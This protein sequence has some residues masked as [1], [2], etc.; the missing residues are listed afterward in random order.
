MWAPN[1][2]DQF[3]VLKGGVS[4]ATTP[5]VNAGYSP[6]VEPTTG[7]PTK[8]DSVGLTTPGISDSWLRKVIVN[9][10]GTPESGLTTAQTAA[11]TEFATR[12]VVPT[13][14]AK[15][16]VCEALKKLTTP[17]T[18]NRLGISSAEVQTVMAHVTT[19][20]PTPDPL[21]IAADEF[22]KESM[23]ENGYTPTELKYR[24][25]VGLISPKDSNI[26]TIL[27]EMT[28]AGTLK[29]G[30]SESDIATAVTTYVQTNFKYISDGVAVEGKPADHWN[31]INETMAAR[32][33]DCEDLSVLTASL[34]MGALSKSGVSDADIHSKVTLA[35]GYLVDKTGAAKGHATV[36]F[37]LDN[38]KS[39]SLDATTDKPPVAFDSLNMLLVLE[40]NDTTFKQYKAIDEFFETAS[41]AKY[42]DV[43][44]GVESIN[45]KLTTLKALLENPVEVPLA[46]A[47]GTSFT[48][49]DSVT[50]VEKNIT[51]HP[52]WDGTS[53]DFGF[54]TLTKTRIAD[55]G[56]SWHSDMYVTTLNEQ[57]FY[58]F[59]TQSR[60]LINRAV[61]MFN[62]INMVL[63]YDEHQ[64]A[65]IA[66][67]GFEDYQKS[68]LL[69]TMGSTGKFKNRFV[70]AMNN[71]LGKISSSIE[72]VVNE[73]FIFISGTNGAQQARISAE[74]EEYG[75]ENLA[76]GILSGL[77]DEI[78]GKF[79]FVRATASLDLNATMAKVNL[80]NA[81][82]YVRYT[83]KFGEGISLWDN[84]ALNPT[85]KS[86]LTNTDSFLNFGSNAVNNMDGFS[87]INNK[88][89]IQNTLQRGL[90]QLE[91]MESQFDS[92]SGD[93]GASLGVGQDDTNSKSASVAANNLNLLGRAGDQGQYAEMGMNYILRLR[94][95]MV[96]YQNFIR[97]T[98]MITEAENSAKRQV[99]EQI[100]ATSGLEE[101]AKNTSSTTQTKSVVVN[102]MSTEIQRQS[103]GLSQIDFATRPFVDAANGYI[104]GRYK[105]A[106]WYKDLT[107]KIQT[108]LEIALQV[109]SAV[110]APIVAT[111][112][113][114]ASLI[115][116]AP[117]PLFVP[118]DPVGWVLFGEINGDYW[119]NAV[120]D[121]ASAGMNAIAQGI[122]Y[123]LELNKIKERNTNLMVQEGDFYGNSANAA[124]LLK[125]ANLAKL[126]QDSVNPYDES[127]ADYYIGKMDSLLYDS[128]T[129]YDSAKGDSSLDAGGGFTYSLQDGKNGET[130][131]STTDFIATRGDGRAVLKGDAM[132][133][134]Q[135]ATS[136]NYMKVSIY[137]SILK[138]LQDAMEGVT[139]TMF[140]R[141]KT[142][143]V[144]NFDGQVDAIIAKESSII[145]TFRYET[146]TRVATINSQWAKEQKEYNQTVEMG[147][148]TA[149]ALVQTSRAVGEFFYSI[150][151][152][153]LGEAALFSTYVAV[154]EAL[155][156]GF[157]AEEAAMLANSTWGKFGFTNID[158][159]STNPYKDSAVNSN[160]VSRLENADPDKFDQ[161]KTSNAQIFENLN[162][163]PNLFP[164]PVASG[165]VDRIANQYGK[166]AKLDEEEAQILNSIKDPDT[167]LTDSSSLAGIGG[168]FQQVD[169]E[170]V[171]DAYK[172][173]T[174]INQI[175]TFMTMIDQAM[176]NA[177]Q[178]ALRSMFGGNAGGGHGALSVMASGIDRYIG[179]IMG[180][181]AGQTGI[182]QDFISEAESRMGA[183]NDRTMGEINTSIQGSLIAANLIFAGVAG[184][185]TYTK[186]VKLAKSG[187]LSDASYLKM[188]RRM[189]SGQMIAGLAANFARIAVG[190]AMMKSVVANHPQIK[191]ELLNYEEDPEEA[192]VN[193]NDS[194][195]EQK[196]NAKLRGTPADSSVNF[197]AKNPVDGGTKT[198][199]SPNFGL[200]GSGS[201]ESQGIKQKVNTGDQGRMERM[202]SRKS[203]SIQVLR[204]IS[205]AMSDA[206][207]DAAEDMGGGPS[208]KNVY[209]GMNSILN[210]Q[211]NLEQQAVGMIFKALNAEVESYNRGVD[212]MV[213]G[214]TGV[215][216]TAV[217]E[218]SKAMVSKAGD[219]RQKANKQSATKTGGSTEEAGAGDNVE[220]SQNSEKPA[221]KPASTDKKASGDTSQKAKTSS[222]EQLNAQARNWEIAAEV[223][224]L[225]GP[226]LA[227]IMVEALSQA[228][229]PDS[230]MGAQAPM[231]S[232]DKADFG[233]Q[234]GDYLSDG[235]NIQQKGGEKSG[236]PAKGG[237]TEGSL[238]FLDTGQ[239]ETAMFANSLLQ[240]GYQVRQQQLSDLGAIYD[241]AGAATA[242]KLKGMA[243]KAIQDHVQEN[244][245]VEE[246]KAADNLV[247][248]H[249]EEA[250]TKIV[251]DA[252]TQTAAPAAQPGG[253]GLRLG[254]RA[255]VGRNMFDVMSGKGGPAGQSNAER[256]LIQKL[257][258]GVADSVSKEHIEVANLNKQ[259]NDKTDTK[260]YDPNWVNKTAGGSVT[261]KAVVDQLR[262]GV[263][264]RAKELD[265]RNG[266]TRS[267]GQM[268]AAEAG[269]VGIIQGRDALEKM[270]GFEKSI[271]GREL[272][273]PEALAAFK[274]AKNDLQVLLDTSTGS[275]SGI[276]RA[277]A[278][279]GADDTFVANALKNMAVGSSAL[280]ELKPV[281]AGVRGAMSMGRGVVSLGGAA[282]RGIGGAFSAIAAP[283][284]MGRAYGAITAP[285]AMR[286]AG[287]SVIG[288]LG[289]VAGAV[290][291]GGGAA[292]GGMGSA[293][294]Y[295]GGAIKNQAGAS[296]AIMK[297]GKYTAY[298]MGLDAGARTELL[299]AEFTKAAGGTLS[300]GLKALA[301]NMAESA[302]RKGF[303][304]KADALLAKVQGASAKIQDSIARGNA[305]TTVSP[306]GSKVT[307]VDLDAQTKGGAAAA[308][309]TEVHM[310]AGPQVLAGLFAQT[311]GD[312]A[313][314]GD[315]P[316]VQMVQGA[317]GK[318]TAQLVDRIDPS[319]HTEVLVTN[320][321]N[322]DQQIRV[323]VPGGASASATADAM[324]K[325]LGEV[326][327]DLAKLRA[328]AAVHTE[329]TAVSGE[330]ATKMGELHALKTAN[331]GQL[332]TAMDR[333][334]ASKEEGGQRN[335]V[336]MDASNR[337]KSQGTTLAGQARAEIEQLKGQQ[338]KLAHDKLQLRLAELKAKNLDATAEKATL[339]ARQLRAAVGEP[340]GDI[341]AA[342]S[343]QEDVARAAGEAAGHRSEAAIHRSDAAGE[344]LMGDRYR[345]DAKMQAADAVGHRF[346]AGGHSS[347]AAR[348]RSDAKMQAADAVGRRN[349]ARA[350]DNA[351][352]GLKTSIATQEKEVKTQ[353]EGLARLNTAFMT[354]I[355]A[356]EKTLENAKRLLEV[357][358]TP[359]D[360]LR[361]EASEKKEEEA[362]FRREEKALR[363]QGD[364]KGAS[365]K[366]VLAVKAEQDKLRLLATADRLVETNKVG[367]KSKAVAKAARALED[368]K[369]TE[370]P[371]V[372]T[373]AEKKLSDAKNQLA[374][375]R[376]KLTDANKKV[377]DLLGAAAK[378]DSEAAKSNAK[379]ADSNAKA[380]DSNA[381]AADSDAKAAG[382]DAKAA[383]SDAKAA[384]SDAKAA[385]SDAKAV[386]AEKAAVRL[387]MDAATLGRSRGVE[388]DA[389]LALAIKAE[390]EAGIHRE[391]AE[392]QHDIVHN[393]KTEVGGQT[394]AVAVKKGLIDTLEATSRGHLAES[395]RLADVHTSESKRLVDTHRVNS[396]RLL[397]EYNDSQAALKKQ[398]IRGLQ[399]RSKVLTAAAKN[400]SGVLVS[401]TSR[402]AALEAEEVDLSKQVVASQMEKE[403][404][405]LAVATGTA[406]KLLTG[407]A[408]QVAQ[409]VAAD[410]E[411]RGMSV[412]VGVDA[413]GKR[414]VTTGAAGAG[415]TT[416]KLSLP[417]THK[418]I[419][420]H[421]PADLVSGGKLNSTDVEKD[422]VDHVGARLQG[423]AS[424][425]AGKFLVAEFKDGKTVLRA[426]DPTK[427]DLSKFVGVTMTRPGGAGDSRTVLMERGVHIDLASDEV[428]AHLGVDVK[429]PAA[430][431]FSLAPNSQVWMDKR[432]A[433]LAPTQNLERAKVLTMDA[434]GNP[435][436]RARLEGE[437]LSNFEA[438][439]VTE[440]DHTGVDIPGSERTILTEKGSSLNFADA[441]VQAALGP[442]GAGNKF[443]TTGDALF[444]Q[445][446]KSKLNLQR[447][448][449]VALSSLEQTLIEMSSYNMSLAVSARLAGT[450]LDQSGLSRA[451]LKSAQSVLDANE[452]G[453]SPS[454]GPTALRGVQTAG[455]GFLSL[456]TLNLADTDSKGNVR[457]GSGPISAVT[458]A[459]GSAYRGAGRAAGNLWGR[460]A[461][462]GRGAQFKNKGASDVG[463]HALD[464]KALE[465]FKGDTGAQGKVMAQLTEKFGGDSVK[466]Q[467]VMDVLTGKATQDLMDRLKGSVSKGDL[468]T[469]QKERGEKLLA[470]AKAHGNENAA[471]SVLALLVKVEDTGLAVRQSA[472]EAYSFSLKENAL[473]RSDLTNV[474]FRFL[475][476]DGREIGKQRDDAY[477]AEGRGFDRRKAAIGF[478][479]FK[480]SALGTTRFEAR[481]TDLAKVFADA[482]S[483]VRKLDGTLK[484]GFRDGGVFRL[485]SE[486]VLGE[487]NR[488][489]T[490]QE[491]EKG[492]DLNLH[493]MNHVE[494]VF[495]AELTNLIVSRD[496]KR[497]SEMIKGALGAGKAGRELVS[498]V[499]QDL[500]V[501]D[502][503]Y[504]SA[505]FKR[506]MEVTIAR[507]SGNDEVMSGLGEAVSTAVEKANPRAEV[508]RT[509]GLTMAAGV[510]TRIKRSI[511]D[512]LFGGGSE[513]NADDADVGTR[514]KHSISDVLFGGGP[515]VSA[516]Q[517]GDTFADSLGSEGS[518]V[519]RAAMGRGWRGQAADF[520]LRRAAVKD[521]GGFVDSSN[522]QAVEARMAGAVASQL[523]GI[524]GFGKLALHMEETD[525]DRMTQALAPAAMTQL[526]QSVAA[527]STGVMTLDRAQVLLDK[528]ADDYTAARSAGKY[529]PFAQRTLAAAEERLNIQLLNYADFAVMAGGRMVGR[530][531]A[532]GVSGGAGNSRE[533]GAMVI[534][535]AAARINKKLAETGISDSGQAGGLGDRLI[536]LAATIRGVA[537]APEDHTAYMQN[538]ATAM[539]IAPGEID[540]SADFKTLADSVKVA[541]A[542]QYSDA[543][544]TLKQGSWAPVVRED[545]QA[546][547]MSGKFLEGIVSA[548]GATGPQ[549]MVATTSGESMLALHNLALSADR[550]A[551]GAAVPD[552][553][554][555]RLKSGDTHGVADM[556]IA[557]NE[558]IQR[559]IEKP[560]RVETM[561]DRMILRK[562]QYEA[563][564]K[565]TKMHLNS[566]FSSLSRKFNTDPVA[567]NVELTKRANGV[568]RQ[569]V[570]LSSSGDFGSI[571]Q[572]LGNIKRTGG[573][574]GAM[575]IQMVGFEVRRLGKQQEFEQYLRQV[576]VRSEQFIKTVSLDKKAQQEA[577]AIF[578]D[579]L[580]GKSA[581]DEPRQMSDDHLTEM[582]GTLDRDDALV[583]VATELG[584]SPA[585]LAAVMTDPAGAGL[586]AKLLA[587]GSAMYLPGAKR[588]IETMLKLESG[589]GAVMHSLK[590]L[591][592]K[593]GAEGLRIDEGSSDPTLNTPDE[594]KRVIEQVIAAQSDP[595]VKAAMS[596]KA[597]GFVT[598]IKVGYKG[599]RPLAPMSRK[600]RET[601]AKIMLMGG[602]AAVDKAR[603]DFQDFARVDPNGAAILIKDLDTVA[604]NHAN[605]LLT[606]LTKNL[607][608]SDSQGLMGL[609]K[610]LGAASAASGADAL[611]MD[612]LATVDS[613]KTMV[614]SFIAQERMGQI[615]DFDTGR[616]TQNVLGGAT[617][618]KADVATRAADLSLQISGDLDPGRLKD[619]KTLV[620]N[621]ATGGG[622][623]SKEDL[624][625]FTAG[626]GGLPEELRPAARELAHL[627]QAETEP[628]LFLAEHTRM[629]GRSDVSTMLSNDS[630]RANL[631]T[632]LADTTVPLDTRMD[633]AATLVKGAISGGPLIQ[634]MAETLTKLVSETLT[635]LVSEAPPST[636]RSELLKP[637]SASAAAIS[638]TLQ[639]KTDA[640]SVA[641]QNEMMPVAQKFEG[642]TDAEKLAF[643]EDPFLADSLA[644]QSPATYVSFLTS[645]AADGVGNRDKDGLRALLEEP[646]ADMGQRIENA[647][648]RTLV[649]AQAA[650][651]GLIPGSMRSAIASGTD[652][653]AKIFTD[654]CKA[655]AS[656]I[657]GATGTP[658]LAGLGEM[659]IQ[660]VSALDRAGQVVAK[661]TEYAGAALT[662]LAT[663]IETKQKNNESYSAELQE[664]CATV[665]GRD[666][667]LGNT[668]TAAI[669]GAPSQFKGLLALS[670]TITTAGGALP[671]KEAILSI[672]SRGVMDGVVKGQAV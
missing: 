291:R 108:V 149:K 568:A 234:E 165:T 503:A 615:A 395:K 13:P 596:S 322:P 227:L 533:L 195:A 228:L 521:G 247:K 654:G 9:W 547:M 94:D 210:Q 287:T 152:I 379:A 494:T 475:A 605:T 574:A 638:A 432:T 631:K 606:G 90:D 326:K 540:T 548:V 505:R 257:M 28:R 194:E 45:D 341:G 447:D 339:N 315:A 376:S 99:A 484:E 215:M 70:N 553:I 21:T 436:L 418:E 213:K 77:A 535:E 667:G 368:L 132:A 443:E 117:P 8:G 186:A 537:L 290:W 146:Q 575:V 490:T 327:W 406:M 416:L 259:K 536:G 320:P 381:K 520:V 277:A 311:H 271:K 476:H 344:R 672:L 508:G 515:G 392:N 156:F 55:F 513:V 89:K 212:M 29:R 71:S 191:S 241:Q 611:S 263:M 646:L 161:E 397:Q 594:F 525:M 659:A 118:I 534:E 260:N 296:T 437:V 653:D 366:A 374:G 208:A 40:G 63:E 88:T 373:S 222:S 36:K 633:C 267:E 469:A 489:T 459:I 18:I 581:P 507:Y 473:Q 345:S 85:E 174:Q 87:S 43:E 151:P 485:D 413:T 52:G 617:D 286:N 250:L 450:T 363:D 115:V 97:S 578:A 325:K 200:D 514:I 136:T 660:T 389:R 159:D 414:V 496:E 6:F 180:S 299:E 121:A 224:E 284:A 482:Q 264:A 549:S 285:G 358:K 600:D 424:M 109:A 601:T 471:A 225:I 104:D 119:S 390:S 192:P 346:A 495:R 356:A 500:A 59:M 317:G 197:D 446:S 572:L 91:D 261:A 640:G 329:L 67:S 516:K 562:E 328:E 273:A 337:E 184:A 662:G 399:I 37:V 189:V 420:A 462:G 559:G 400:T 35:A 370:G 268:G 73:M 39:L 511:S 620:D 293:A 545:T 266:S 524:E 364:E 460:G 651:P 612:T 542:R 235:G 44:H 92:T 393:L 608:P 657:A 283:G 323:A 570:E 619:M 409:L 340:E 589:D 42:F 148:A 403:S 454:V 614:D 621:M 655:A 101:G 417:G 663:K 54:Y 65:E 434:T 229:A 510:G 554:R 83:M 280:P 440:K 162:M 331:S 472:L 167:I 518:D 529:T 253:H 105:Y 100:S 129:Q 238:G 452:L 354:K 377:S 303:Q 557:I 140:G 96:D 82:A 294:S 648:P 352:K 386:E 497:A 154:E 179:S 398:E 201:K 602:P 20:S 48:Y 433:A 649:L 588:L 138:V 206:K 378:S 483:A 51:Q 131:M 30:M 193:P 66:V 123:D 531:M 157:A 335:K 561:Q 642:K 330:L 142:S 410:R 33:G 487:G 134:H 249:G 270:D 479:D 128:R 216:T 573:E 426:M 243:K 10:A 488:Y 599:D 14:G 172:K 423:A 232:T 539:M 207:G 451:D 144:S 319:T 19:M 313:G 113:K 634:D 626:I 385:G 314:V 171:L 439:T 278:T 422:I 258:M 586:L 421:V 182:F 464:E 202:V 244:A 528:A 661:R 64:A 664:F 49:L 1:L 396:E 158:Y 178:N 279:L 160:F 641:L 15:S 583:S 546:K 4:P 68:E 444:L 603:S 627:A 384:D 133:S 493:M 102:A 371:G 34:L 246:D 637:G 480:D 610:A 170:K 456:V 394:R 60:D 112:A 412:T 114:A 38:G 597:E 153:P 309:A 76:T 298:F 164:S 127:T 332:K 111:T 564:S 254:E 166:Y 292:V 415:L 560:L 274:E 16:L 455:R 425:A 517:V 388:R 288:G 577:R 595:K 173:M 555:A 245:K 103:A 300:P 124:Q 205:M 75:R 359:G 343:M 458:S 269:L 255:S 289:S 2:D 604:P 576:D 643:M 541:A 491:M 336:S 587:E 569:V 230:L 79:S 185:R 401:L 275:K 110:Y 579:A 262:A 625:T 360:T 318:M 501:Q 361:N 624:Q 188:A 532:S 478:L 198:G 558:M 338:Q 120:P 543:N 636:A 223:L 607:A 98:Y 519:R 411:L 78:S 453:N 582:R 187:G 658:D 530:D 53:V 498:R 305:A 590:K 645:S 365:K 58:D 405:T 135:L 375:D 272:D 353:T 169:F 613:T 155:K 150:V 632:A 181:M 141:G 656:G 369:G 24:N 5:G 598:A 204:D 504:G 265:V 86:N 419:D 25:G 351:A 348:Y 281:T 644:T 551:A 442:K 107:A 139:A 477:A 122:Y 565:D 199:A 342:R 237:K 380:A 355:K 301:L 248:E 27:E 349:A 481:G 22:R 591:G 41:N 592:Y 652:A 57:A 221:E 3:R 62:V 56:N 550:V 438:H 84:D 252:M 523:S 463:T 276:M 307:V 93:F 324:G 668:L 242:N 334:D 512:V 347:D 316:I 12:G 665:S 321:N 593:V 666:P 168:N 125:D 310:E 580:S 609:S 47:D 357:A 69:E 130:N 282:I 470:I 116:F 312:T 214:V 544:R 95:Y 457:V 382:S 407:H 629:A 137:L 236:A 669:D 635:N 671:E 239:L 304:G 647:S 556:V 26:Q 240:A 639:G 308:A 145:D 219:L 506:M 350:L 256:R 80:E 509:A 217:Q 333:L 448:I 431:R 566:D 46:S 372:I 502:K 616:I 211:T 526:M 175:R 618:F 32:G 404:R 567:A 387:G 461:L 585:K 251:M 499:M 522:V 362:K 17:G 176:Y 143:T 584:G 428:Q 163:D 445:D 31:T 430:V 74:L 628:N 622:T 630:I 623:I 231:F 435:V 196:K 367:D 190:V 302:D 297:D 81:Q 650:S 61:M 670:S 465:K 306:T 391:A 126:N 486:S 23:A 220:G 72:T 563:Y 492:R 441:K 538:L 233:L 571:T 408:S 449:A 552:E 383:G 466:A 468:M 427:D 7:A 467:R 295:V 209:R 226:T 177:K 147:R 106:R 474:A 183:I 429:D 203:R 11:V 50:G 218:G 527:G 402:I